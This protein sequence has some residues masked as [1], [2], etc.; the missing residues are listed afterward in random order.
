MSRVKAWR[1]VRKERRLDAFS[2]EGARRF[3]GR[4]NPPGWPVV[5]LSEALSLAALE[6][7]VHQAERLPKGEFVYFPVSFPAS[8]V[9]EVDLREL[10]EKWCIYPPQGASIELGRC[11][12]EA[13]QSAILRVPSIHVPGEWNYLFNPKVGD[14]SEFEIGAGRGFQFDPRFQRK[15]AGYLL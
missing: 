13:R 9:E 7:L 12:L 3:G 15:R 2:G 6:V 10:D 4:W 5:Y 11:W 1:L 14:E 8:W